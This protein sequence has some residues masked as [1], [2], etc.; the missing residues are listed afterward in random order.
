MHDE[1]DYIVNYVVG[2]LQEAC[3][4]S[5]L[6]LN[7]MPIDLRWG[8]NSSKSLEVCMTQVKRCRE[9]NLMPYFLCLIG[10]RYGYIPDSL[11]DDLR[12][13]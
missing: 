6:S 8:V 2:K 7:I 10:D 12:R 11:E 9:Q 3:D 1:R 4:R 13:E 5:N